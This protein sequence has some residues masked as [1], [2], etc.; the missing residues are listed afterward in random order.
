MLSKT[1]QN[2]NKE[3]KR[4]GEEVRQKTNQ[5][6]KMLSAVVPE[7]N[8]TIADTAQLC[9]LAVFSVSTDPHTVE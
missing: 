4:K 8:Y 3:G 6:I 5:A 9:S 2:H 7:V 1:G